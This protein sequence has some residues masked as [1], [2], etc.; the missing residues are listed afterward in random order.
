MHL[1]L[2]TWYTFRWY[3]IDLMG[4]MILIRWASKI[5]GYARRKIRGEWADHHDKIV[6]RIKF[7]KSKQTKMG[8]TTEEEKELDVMEGISERYKARKRSLK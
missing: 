8:L 7:L 2:E 4:I 3:L 1:I 6:E 5:Y